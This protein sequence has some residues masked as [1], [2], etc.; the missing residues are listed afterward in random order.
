MRVELRVNTAGTA[1]ESVG[2][3]AYR[4]AQ[5][6]LTN[7]RKHAPGAAASVTVTGAPGRGLTVEVHNTAPVPRPCGQIRPSGPG[8][9]LIGLA[10]RAALAGGRLDYAPTDT[11]GF[12]LSAWLPWPA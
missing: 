10:E 8:Q 4:I 3:T 7:V 6:G 2:R 5:E 9:G 11:G 1:P 12:R